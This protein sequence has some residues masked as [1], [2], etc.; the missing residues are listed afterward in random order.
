VLRQHNFVQA[1][2][3]VALELP[4]GTASK[5]RDDIGWLI[6]EL[7]VALPALFETDDYRRPSTSSSR[8]R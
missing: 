4:A 6:D 5:L 7:R 2:E 3:P 1:Q 8:N